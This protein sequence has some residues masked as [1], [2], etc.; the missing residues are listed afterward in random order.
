MDH[1]TA[2]DLRRTLLL[3]QVILAALV[4]LTLV[5][6]HAW[7]S[8]AAQLGAVALLLACYALLVVRPLAKTIGGVVSDTLRRTEA[9]QREVE[10]LEEAHAQA[11]ADVQ[12]KSAF[13]AA[14]SHEIRTPMNGVIGM[15]SLLDES[16]LDSAQRDFV[17]TIRSSGDVLLTLI[18]DV[19][20][21]SK[22]EAGEV[23]ADLQPTPLRPL[24]E[25]AFDLV[26]S[27]AAAKGL[28]LVYAPAPGVPDQIET[29]PT[30]L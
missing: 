21:L 10:R 1:P 20:D 19:L 12:A 9:L 15:A 22:I 28:D 17:S 3:T 26:A 16:L 25:A 27:R 23:T 18:N 29:D 4:L 5:L 7:D 30:R 24:V 8:L 11:Q 13:L 6:A 2:R 14:M